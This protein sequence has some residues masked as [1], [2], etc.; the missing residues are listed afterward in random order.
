MAAAHYA[1]LTLEDCNYVHSTIEIESQEVGIDG[2]DRSSCRHFGPGLLPA[3]SA[4]ADKDAQ[5]HQDTY[6]ISNA[7]TRADAHA[8]T[9]RHPY[10]YTHAHAN[11]DEHPHANSDADRYPRT[12]QHAYPSTSGY[13]EPCRPGGSGRIYG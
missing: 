8:N 1:R 9:H 11:L 5:T 7:D 2:L 6:A 4:R 10:A 12:D 3:D 13:T